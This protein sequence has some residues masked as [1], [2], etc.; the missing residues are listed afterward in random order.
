MT[1]TWTTT[2][3]AFTTTVTRADNQLRIYLTD[4]S[5]F[6]FGGGHGALDDR[7]YISNVTITATKQSRFSVGE[8]LQ[9]ADHAL[10]V[11]GSDVQLITPKFLLGDLSSQFVSGSAGNLEISSSNFHLQAA[12]DVSMS[13]NIRAS[14]GTIAGWTLAPD[15]FA[16]GG[17]DEYIALIPETGIQ[18]GNTV[19]ANAPFSVTNEG[20]LKATSGTIGGFTLGTNT[21]TATDFTIDPSGKSISLGS[22]TN[23]FVVDG[24][25]GLQL[26]HGTFGSAPFSVTKA[27]VLKATSGTVGGWTLGSETIVGSNL[28]LRSSGI[29]ETNDFASGVDGGVASKLDISTVTAIAHTDTVDVEVFVAS[30]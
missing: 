10:T 3:I 5:S 18:L 12:G 17:D 19:F 20:V 21:F 9:F 28:T 22:G 16:G 30:S 2:Q 23:I 29:I 4:G 27:G 13:G 14:G 1:G 8:E 7:V 26:G 11:S 24:D 6:T 25:V 15:R